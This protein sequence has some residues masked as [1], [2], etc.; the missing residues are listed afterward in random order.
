MVLYAVYGIVSI[1]IMKI[2]LEVFCNIL[3][4]WYFS[5]S[6][7]VM[8]IILILFLFTMWRLHVCTQW[9]WVSVWRLWLCFWFY[10]LQCYGCV[11]VSAHNIKYVCFC[12]HWDVCVFVF[13]QN[14]KAVACLFLHKMWCVYFAHIVVAVWL[15]LHTEKAVFFL[16]SPIF[17]DPV[18]ILSM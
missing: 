4:Q 3:C 18:N 10:N 17:L 14:V 2:S 1:L 5:S 12:M 11:F 13:A 16:Q 6:L 15:F 7:F 8:G 9:H